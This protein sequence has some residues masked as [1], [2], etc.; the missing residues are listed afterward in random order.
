M[1]VSAHWPQAK[2]FGLAYSCG[3]AGNRTRLPV[4][5]VSVPIR[6]RRYLRFHTRA[7]ELPGAVRTE[8]QASQAQR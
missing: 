7:S 8:R 6:S 1:L 3:A 5:S 4:R 2:P